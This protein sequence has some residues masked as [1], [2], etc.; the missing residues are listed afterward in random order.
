[1]KIQIIIIFLFF[2]CANA[3]AQ[4]VRSSQDCTSFE[5]LSY[6]NGVDTIIVLS[7]YHDAVRLHIG[8]NLKKLEKQ[9]K[10]KANDFT[11][12]I[13]FKVAGCDSLYLGPAARDII[14]T[15]DLMAEKD[16]NVLLKLRCIIYKGFRGGMYNSY[17]FFVIDK[18][19]PCIGNGSN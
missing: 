11:W 12:A 1:M 5:N 18:V 8:D 6:K 2:L 14:S 7:N 4:E 3:R 15:S 9:K 17:P 10:L 13:Y 19:E 16:S